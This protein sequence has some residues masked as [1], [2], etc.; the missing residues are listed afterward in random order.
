M[1]S[2]SGAI[3]DSSI[4]SGAGCFRACMSTYTKAH[5]VV[6]HRSWAATP[7]LALNSL[8]SVSLSQ[9][10]PSHFRS[11]FRADSE[12]SMNE[13]GTKESCSLART[14]GLGHET[15]VSDE[16]RDRC[17]TERPASSEEPTLN[18][19]AFL[20]RTNPR[21]R[22]CSGII[23]LVRKGGKDQDAAMFDRSLVDIVRRGGFGFSDL[24]FPRV[25]NPI[26]E[27]THPL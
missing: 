14:F 8:P 15:R 19:P 12:N 18:C 2:Q 22:A 13:S 3:C 26:R 1:C 4:D 24:A 17:A 10:T 25:I 7:S 6:Q 5:N 11:K 20:P 23:G 21:S 27:Q 9:S 16:N